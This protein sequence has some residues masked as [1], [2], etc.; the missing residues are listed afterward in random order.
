MTTFS[1]E[2]YCQF[3]EAL[4]PNQTIALFRVYALTINGNLS[5]LRTF[6]QIQI[7]GMFREHKKPNIFLLSLSF[8]PATVTTTRTSATS[9]VTCTTS[10]AMVATVWTVRRTA[11]APT[12]NGAKRT[13]SCATT[14]TASTVPATRW[15]H[16][17]CNATRRASASASLA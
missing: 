4:T 2:S 15:A 13:F 11:M 3:L 1:S 5:S 10:P 12:A 14:A 6:I 16:G 7:C 9:T 8:Q 17:R